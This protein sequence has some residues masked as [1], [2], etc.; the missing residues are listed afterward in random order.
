MRQQPLTIGNHPNLKALELTEPI[1]DILGFHPYYMWNGTQERLQTTTKDGFENYL[2]ACVAI[3][4]RTGK[5]LIA[6][7]TVWGARDD[8]TH[9]EVMRYTLGELAKRDIGYTV[10][11]LHH[12]LVADLHRDE[13]GPVGWPE[14]LHFIEADGS[15]RA[16]HEA[17]NEF[18]PS[19]RSA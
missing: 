15:L 2:D 3:A 7:E 6:N 1:S 18:A 5:E 9:V 19:R 4:E 17:F 14:W 16:G 12:S 8:A 13:Y 10:H 11:A